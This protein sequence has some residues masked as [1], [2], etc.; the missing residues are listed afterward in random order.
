[1]PRRRGDTKRE[2]VAVAAQLFQQRGYHGFS[3]QHVAET[4]NVR[5]AAV[6]YYFPAKADLGEAVIAVMREDF[7]WW[8]RQ[9]GERRLH[10][11]ERIER[12]LALESRYVSDAKVCPLGVA[13]V[14]FEGL[15][16]AMRAQAALLLEEVTAFLESALATGRADGSLLFEGR[17]HEAAL[18]LLAATQGAL[19]ISRLRGEACYQA[20]TEGIRASL[21]IGLA[22]RSRASA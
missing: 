9:V 7:G 8:A 5:S 17:P 14:E 19:Q 4:L 21:G 10:G 16:D 6:H 11:A 20:V 22:V 15:P 1:M 12:F 2:I 18:H 13:G 3:Y